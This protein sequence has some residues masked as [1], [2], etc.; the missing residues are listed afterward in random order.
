MGV[1]EGRN[2]AITKTDPPA[3]LQEKR[4][5]WKCCSTEKLG[6]CRGKVQGLAARWGTAVGTAMGVSAGLGLEAGLVPEET[7][8]IDPRIELVTMFNS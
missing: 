1:R 3:S 2:P 6:L 8:C 7:R 5:V 4:T